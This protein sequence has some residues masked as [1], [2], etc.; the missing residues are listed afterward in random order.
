MKNRLPRWDKKLMR[1]G[2]ERLEE[3]DVLLQNQYPTGAVYLAGYAVECGL[4]AVLLS[5]VPRARHEDVL[6]EF[7]GRHG[8]DFDWLRRRYLARGGPGL[9]VEIRRD[10]E[11]VQNWSTNLRY[12]A[13]NVAMS[14][15]GSFLAATKR[16]LSF[17]SGRL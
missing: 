15:A 12:S 8:H 17:F 11:A 5:Q 14:E 9:P 7:R 6:T 4:K 13:A 16:L 1:C 10:F 2:R 3:A